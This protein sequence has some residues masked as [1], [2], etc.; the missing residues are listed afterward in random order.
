MDLKTAG[1]CRIGTSG[2]VYTHWKDIFYPPRVPVR[3]WLQW[4]AQSFNTV[5]LNNSFYRL[6]S[7]DAF[8]A[9]R[10]RVPAEFIFA[11]KF[12]RYG[13]HLMRLKN[14]RETIRRFQTN[15]KHLKRHLG[16]VLVQLPPNWNVNCQ[17]LEEFL[18]RVP[19]G[20]Q[21]SIEF[22]DS[23]WLCEEVYAVLR[24]HR[25]ALCIHDKIPGHP[26]EL[27]A[28][29][30]YFRFHGSPQNDGKY[31]AAQLESYAREITAF[32]GSGLDVYA[33]FNN[34]WRGFAIANALALKNLLG[35]DSPQPLK[36]AQGSA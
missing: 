7:A 17:R 15:A 16:P 34:D 3:D 20:Q 29:W 21:W 19:R 6:P 4:Y 25:A 14:P 28:N 26:R 13:S 5:E 1:R 11:V 33:Y 2:Y 36:L 18:A 27:T 12:S 8:N 9:W 23:R 31:S 22:R 30:T 24:R 10:R 32:I 35:I